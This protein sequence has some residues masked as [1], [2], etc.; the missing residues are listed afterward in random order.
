MARGLRLLHVRGR[1][2]RT[3]QVVRLERGQAQGLVKVAGAARGAA[4]RSLRAPRVAGGAAEGAGARGRGHAAGVAG[5]VGTDEVGEEEAVRAVG[6]V[7]VG[8]GGG[9]WVAAAHAVGGGGGGGG[10]EA[11]VGTAGAG[12][13]GGRRRVVA[14]ALGVGG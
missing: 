13:A 1:D 9:A 5:G 6:V 10:G 3:G 4:A 2:G 7:G 11:L 14:A 8:D 12:A